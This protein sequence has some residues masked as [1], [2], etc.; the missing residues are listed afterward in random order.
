MSTQL[1]PKHPTEHLDVLG[2]RLKL[3]VV[4]PSVNTV[5]QPEYDDMRPHGVT[6]HVARIYLSKTETALDEVVR[7]IDAAL[8]DAVESVLTCE[9]AAVVLGISIE[10]VYNDPKAGEAIQA[11]LSARFGDIDLVHAG[12]AL[13]AA[14]QALG[15]ADG[16]I[17]LVSPYPPEARP[18]LEA[19]VGEAGYELQ[20]A[21]FLDAQSTVGIAE[22][23]PER[24]RREL[25]RLAEARPRAI[26]QF[27]ANMCMGRLAAE[28]ERW[29]ALPVIAVNTATYW[30]ALRRYGITDRVG[31][32]GR[33]LEEF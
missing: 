19:F 23:Q 33:L 8:E 1:A 31:G 22:I 11:R 7:G 20:D 30:H 10:A 5:V 4:T 13:P 15:V 24:L 17:S 28:A 25:V 3:G 21:T 6:N 29:L 16:P 9:P 26:V 14:L 32:F 2:Y 27:G 18:H 12:D